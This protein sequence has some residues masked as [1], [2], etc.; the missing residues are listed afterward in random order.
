MRSLSPSNERSTTMLR[1]MSQNNAKVEVGVSE[2][3]SFLRTEEN[4]PCV[5]FVAQE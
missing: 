4:K 1:M 3:L 2:G 5:V